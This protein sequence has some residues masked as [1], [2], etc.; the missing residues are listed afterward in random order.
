V[1]KPTL[2]AVGCAFLLLWLAFGASM[3]HWAKKFS[4]KPAE[5]WSDFLPRWSS[6]HF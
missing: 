4:E 1:S 3:L 5:E 2:F 6:L